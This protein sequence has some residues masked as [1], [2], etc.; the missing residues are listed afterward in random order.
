[1]LILK[2]VNRQRGRGKG[3]SAC[4]L[5]LCPGKADTHSLPASTG[6]CVS[7][8]WRPAGEPPPGSQGMNAAWPRELRKPPRVVYKVWAKKSASGIRSALFLCQWALAGLAPGSGLRYT[9][10]RAKRPNHRGKEGGGIPPGGKPARGPRKAPWSITGPSALPARTRTC[11][12]GCS[13]Q[14]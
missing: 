14:E 9:D 1:M 4:S 6:R 2:P 5:F 7:H 10:T 12:A 3:R 8:K 13:T 11:C